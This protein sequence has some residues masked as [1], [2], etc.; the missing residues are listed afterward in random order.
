MIRVTVAQTTVKE[1]SGTSTKGKPYKL[2]FQTGYG[3]T[4]DKDG[5]APPFPEK[6]EIMLENDQPAYAP[7]DYQLHPSSV[8]VNRDGRLDISA[9]LT[10]LTKKPA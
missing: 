4:V 1:I 5:N 6:F 9:R 7:G 8:Y 3:H 2:R 10:P